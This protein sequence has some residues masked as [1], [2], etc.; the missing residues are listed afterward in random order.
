LFTPFDISAGFGEEVAFS[1][2]DTPL[3]DIFGFALYIFHAPWGPPPI[4]SANSADGKDHK[5][6]WQMKDGGRTKMREEK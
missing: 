6:C 4:Y 1:T 3:F 5:S 2:D